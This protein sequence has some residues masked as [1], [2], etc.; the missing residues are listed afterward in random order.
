MADI[1]YI[2]PQSYNNLSL[3]D[4]GVLGRMPADKVVFFGSSLWDCDRMENVEMN[5]WFNYNSI[6]NPIKKGLSYA[7]T[8]RRIVSYVRKNPV[9]VAHIQWL[10][11][12]HLDWFFL[13]FLQSRGIKVIYTAHNILPHDTDRKFFD[14]YR[15]YYHAVDNIIVHSRRTKTE[16]MEQ[17][18]LPDAKIKII[19]HGILSF[20]NDGEALARRVE[21]LK[22]SLGLEGKRVFASLG[23]Q[24][25]YKGVDHIVKVWAETPSLRNNPNVKLLLVGK[26][27][28]IDYS[29]VKELENVV[30]IDERISNLDFEAFIKLSDL[31]LLPYRKIS[32]SGV[33]F[34]ALDNNVPVAVSDVGGL[35]EPL[36]F[37]DVGWNIGS[38]EGPGLKKLLL[39]LVSDS[40]PLDRLHGADEEFA[41]VRRV[42]SWEAISAATA[43]LYDRMISIHN[44]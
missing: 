44:S 3:Y 12:W 36:A 40:A 19:P 17:F 10:R 16:L 43:D 22:R 13:R 24:T 5:L 39:R 27:A 14:K 42:Y 11:I 18:G 38:P 41:K 26:N 30:I 34:T 25:F 23:K 4:S 33:L 9:K 20:R 7:N 6:T 15:R 31:I 32:Q 1:L 8:I 37:G 21:E 28:G 29:A 2:D 35:A